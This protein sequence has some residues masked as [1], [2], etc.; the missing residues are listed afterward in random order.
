M[1]GRIISLAGAGLVWGAAAAQLQPFRL[2]TANQALFQKGGEDRFFAPTPGRPWTS[3]SFG[4]VRSDGQ[5]MHEGVDIRSLRQDKRGEPTDPVLATAD[6]TVAYINRDPG[7][8]NY[9]QYLVL[10][11]DLEGLEVYS[12]YA[13]LSQ[14]RAALEPGQRVKAGQVCATMGRTS[15][16]ASIGK[17]RAH[18]HFELN[19][20]YNDRFAEWFKKAQPAERNDHGTWNGHNLAGFDA[21][22]VFLEEKAKGSRFSLKQFLQGQSELCRVLVHKPEFSYVRRYAGLVRPNPALGQQFVA[23][24]EL[25]LDYN[26]LPFQIIPRP[27]GDFDGRAKY[28]LLS[29][30]AAEEKRHP[31]RHLVAREGNGWRLTPQAESLLELLTY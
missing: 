9:G 19:L 16:G 3:G 24:Y 23:G 31:C 2:P 10:R 30:N 21:R 25:V 6:G 11:H 28:R 18:L 1:T 14:I 12:L 7:L 20:L 5:Q 27:P 26:G 15:S 4:C 13:H 22:R 17:D 29:V 8:S